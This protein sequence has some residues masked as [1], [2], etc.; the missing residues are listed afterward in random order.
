MP[1]SISR[2]DFGSLTPKPT[3]NDNKTNLVTPPPVFK[4]KRQGY[5]YRTRY[6]QLSTNTANGYLINLGLASDDPNYSMPLWINSFS[7]GLRMVGS[8]AQG[9]SYR[10]YFPRN[11]T[12]DDII[13]HGQTVSNYDY[14]RMVEFITTH[15]RSAL[16]GGNPSSQN[17]SGATPLKFLLK[18]KDIDLRDKVLYN[19]HSSY[20]YNAYVKSIEAGAERFQNAR[21]YQLQLIVASSYRDTTTETMNFQNLLRSFQTSVFTPPSIDNTYKADMVA[22]EDAALNTSDFLFTSPTDTIFGP[23]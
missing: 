13:I 14:D 12:F 15:H 3:P 10:S 17:V 5:Y 22:V 7:S 23:G 21:E 1:E 19:S 11:V 16:S 20:V 2:N 8:N 18:R 6:D 9:P 4:A